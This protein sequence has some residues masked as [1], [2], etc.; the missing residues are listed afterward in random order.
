MAINKEK[1]GYTAVFEVLKVY[2]E[3]FDD[4]YKYTDWIV[5]LLVGNSVTTTLLMFN[6]TKLVWEWDKDW[7][8]GE[9]FIRILAAWPLPLVILPPFPY[10]ARVGVE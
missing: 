2:M 4:G 1:D 5:Q 8:E 3:T 10:D 9:K 7:W 6:S